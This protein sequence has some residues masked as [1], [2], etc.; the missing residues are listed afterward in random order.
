MEAG[1]LLPLQGQR[2]LFLLL[3]EHVA[4][5]T[6]GEGG[7]LS[8]GGALQLDVAVLLGYDGLKGGDRWRGGD[9]WVNFWKA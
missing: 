2:P 8:E 4:T 9:T 3:Q 1:Q 6:A 7:T 5:V